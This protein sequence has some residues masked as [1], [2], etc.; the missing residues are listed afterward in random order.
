MSTYAVTLAL[1]AMLGWGVWTVLANEATRTIHP[2]V[3]MILSY[4]ASVVLAV[5]FVAF[6]HDTLELHRE[7]ISFALAAGI[8]AGIGAIA[9]YAALSHGRVGIVVTISALYFVVAAV[10]GVLFLGETLTPRQALGIGFAV[11]AVVLVAG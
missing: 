4:A 9:F 1:A 6:R 3:A 8:F 2:E 10:L 5:G 11:L 7:G